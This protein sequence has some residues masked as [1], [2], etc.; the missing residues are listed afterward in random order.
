M[1][2]PLTTA[3]AVLL[4]TTIA[5]S[6]AADE[7]AL[8]RFMDALGRQI[9]RLAQAIMADDLATAT[10]AAEAIANHPQLGLA[11]RGRELGRLGAAVSAFRQADANVRRAALAVKEAAQ[12]GDREALVAGF[13]HLA[14]TCLACRNR[15]RKPVGRLT[16]MRHRE[17]DHAEFL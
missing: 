6:V 10:A 14:N 16:F 13:H 15:S 1:K 8:R 11:E 9:G 3:G 7:H 4:V 17:N 2:D 5:W 12:A